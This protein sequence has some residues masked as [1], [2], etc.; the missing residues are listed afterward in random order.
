MITCYTYFRIDIRFICAANLRL[1]NF[2]DNI[3]YPFLPVLTS[4]L[5]NEQKKKLHINVTSFKFTDWFFDNGDKYKI[6]R[7]IDK[8]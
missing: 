2:T 1:I 6:K 8:I 3:S 4:K 5:I 7:N